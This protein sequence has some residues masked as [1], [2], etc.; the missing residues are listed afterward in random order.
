MMFEHFR[1]ITIKNIEKYAPVRR[2]KFQSQST[3]I[4]VVV[5]GKLQPRP[6]TM[7]PIG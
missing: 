5:F 2:C 7:T 6:W 1:N 3:T 4:C